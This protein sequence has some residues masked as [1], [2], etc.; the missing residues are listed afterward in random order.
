M[1]NTVTETALINL[2]IF[3][4][5]KLYYFVVLQSLGNPLI[6]QF[7]HPHDPLF[8]PNLLIIWLLAV[9]SVALGSYWSGVT[10]MER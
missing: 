9:I 10:T 2:N 4:Q 3:R 6:I 1:S 7:W 8:D 5:D